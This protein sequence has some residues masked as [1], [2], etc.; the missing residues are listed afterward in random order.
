MT[1][2]RQRSMFSR[3]SLLARW[4]ASPSRL[5]WSVFDERVVQARLVKRGKK[6]QLRFHDDGG[7]AFDEGV[8]PAEADAL[9][10]SDRWQL[11]PMLI[12]VQTSGTLVATHRSEMLGYTLHNRHAELILYRIAQGTL[13]PGPELIETLSSV[14]RL[15]EELTRIDLDRQLVEVADA[16]MPSKK[17]FGKTSHLFMERETEIG[18]IAAVAQAPG[19]TQETIDA[20]ATALNAAIADNPFR[21]DDAPYILR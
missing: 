6:L 2:A 10:R 1:L 8:T 16:R 5:G 18:R 12:E 14:P 19:A 4:D 20:A 17:E 21:L 13:G 11:V 15:K 3:K 7:F 9:I